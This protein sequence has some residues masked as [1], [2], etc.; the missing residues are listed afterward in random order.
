MGLSCT[1]APYGAASRSALREFLAAAKAEDP[2]APV[3]VAV[4]SNYAGLALRRALAAEGL[5]EG[6]PG[7][8]NVRFMVLARVAE[9]LGAPPLAARGLRPLTPGYR[10]EAVRAA[11]EGTPGPLAGV[12]LTAS[13]LARIHGLFGE[14]DRAGE[15][16]RATLAAEGGELQRALIALHRD[17]RARVAGFY[18][19]DDLARAASDAVERPEAA[20]AIGALAVYLPAEVTP[21]QR[22]LIDALA[23]ATEVAVMLGLSGDAAIDAPLLEAWGV[24][25]LA[26]PPPE[27]VATRIVQA[28]DPEEEV[29]EALR[30]IHT[31]LL[32]GTPLFRMAILYRHADPYARIAVEQLDAAGL[33]WNGPSARTLGQTVAGRTLVGLL[34]LREQRFERLA[35]TGWLN[36]APILDR[37]DG[38]P[39]PSHRGEEIARA[40]GVVRGAGQWRER[41]GRYRNRVARERE[42]LASEADE[43]HDRVWRMRRVERE[44]DET[45][46]LIEFMDEL[47]ERV[48]AAPAGQAAWSAFA[49]WT[50]DALAR[51]L[52][53][54]AR[55]GGWPE[56]E[57]EA[58][59]AVT[60]AI[61][62]LGGLDELGHADG[63]R[64]LDAVERELERPTGRRGQFGR[65]VFVGRL[66]DAA[67]LDFDLVLV[68]GN[69]EGGMP[70]AQREDPLLPDE[71]RRRAGVEGRAAR[72]R[73]ERRDY[74]AA[75][76]TAPERVLL[77]PRAELRGQ[78]ARLPG[79][80]L[81]ESASAL[82]GERVF[83]SQLEGW[84][85]AAWFEQVASFES[86]IGSAGGL[87]G[88]QEYD[89]RSLHRY[90]AAGR[91]VTRHY[92]AA[93]EGA[94]G[95]GYAL[96]RA[97]RSAA[98]TRWDGRLPGAGARSPLEGE[99]ALSPTALQ[100]WAECPFR[101]FVGH[102]LGVA[103][104]EE[105]EDV[106]VISALE[107]GSLIHGV[108]DR[109]FHAAPPRRSPDERWSAEERSLL[110]RIAEEECAGA[111]RDGVAGRPL[112]WERERAGILRDLDRFLDEDEALRERLGTVQ[113]GSERPFGLDGAAGIDVAV[114]DGRT[115]RLRGRIDRVDRSPDGRTLVVIDYKTGYVRDG[116]KALPTDPV[117]G[118]RLLQ[119][120]IYAL[121]ARASEGG[122][123]VERVE[124][125]Y[126][127]VTERGTFGM[128][129]Y[130]LD[131]ARQA[132]FLGVL[133]AITAGIAGGVFVA[134]PGTLTH[135]GYE[136]CSYCPFEPVCPADRARAWEHKRS[137]AGLAGYLA[138]IEGDAT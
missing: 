38:G 8:L 90:R 55:T 108:L 64:F 12:S 116:H 86:S 65:G 85:G 87:A 118:G 28:T 59:R 61:D 32:E 24:D 1:A 46:R 15:E 49:G 19:E 107:K 130:E 14:L 106:L 89:L 42:E 128:H 47:V 16:E 69:S 127:F 35:V 20:A 79:R 133:G 70:P 129:G 29:R 39:A 50:S 95:G 5:Q 17:Y 88:P 117:H 66:A 3:T 97:R 41:L 37:Q 58:L 84:R 2:L 21:A 91:D 71:L 124:S 40:A 13:T 96:Q 76:S 111:E 114:A 103:E 34:R 126:W 11:M 31:R 73:R 25:L 74:L 119:L 63:G 98:W 45:G 100:S 102:L 134:N 60:E 123:A 82:A 125:H 9:L 93:S 7:L 115:V 105:P 122:P 132:R 67:G 22:G 30:R 77:F 109:F 75:L 81:L 53:G 43:D 33:P 121:A 112:L 138:L 23:D 36:A 27:P 92:L 18:S 101:F 72:G 62:G 26:T 83:A 113:V 120:P 136:H 48:D 94:L 51:Y 4:P 131:G 52:G 44:L 6:A 99:R 10:I 137:D 68:P 80:W 104:R 57:V 54:E 78:R 110:M 56:A 135:R